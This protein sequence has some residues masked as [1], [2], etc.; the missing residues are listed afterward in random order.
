MHKL[1]NAFRNVTK[2]ECFA[3]CANDGRCKYVLWSNGPSYCAPNK[4]K[5]FTTEG[6]GM[7]SSNG[8]VEDNPM[9]AADLLWAEVDAELENPFWLGRIP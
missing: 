6:N 5:K 8:I 2:D 7:K 1:M 3:S 4:C 9:C